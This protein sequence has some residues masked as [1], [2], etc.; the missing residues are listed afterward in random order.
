MA[1][2]L[3]D[4]DLQGYP[5]SRYHLALMV[6]Y[7]RGMEQNLA[8]AGRLFKRVCEVVAP[9]TR[10]LDRHPN[11]PSASGMAQGAD[12][13]HAPSMLML[14]SL[15]VNGQGM[16]RNLELGRRWVEKAAASGD[17][18]VA[19]RASRAADELSALTA[20]ATRRSEMVL[21]ELRRQRNDSTPAHLKP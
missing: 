3:P 15:L 8:R 14:G 2:P 1:S 12:A 16:P 20:S 18:E 4:S 9:P 6:A 17:E 19:W 11:F 21:T 10:P 5:P 7:G 13:G